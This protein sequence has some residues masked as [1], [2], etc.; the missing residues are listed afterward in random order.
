M[1]SFIV[2]FGLSFFLDAHVHN[3]DIKIIKLFFWL[4][5]IVPCGHI[6]QKAYIKELTTYL[7]TLKVSTMWT[8]SSTIL[9]ATI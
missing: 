3:C 7:K 4:Q 9:V 6:S 1:R 5:D 2:S 8:G